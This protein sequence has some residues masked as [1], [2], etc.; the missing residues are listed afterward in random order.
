MNIKNVFHVKHFTLRIT[1]AVARSFG[2]GPYRKANFH[3]GGV[4]TREISNTVAGARV[5]KLT[6]LGPGRGRG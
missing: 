2:I 1:D 4:E 5:E 3:Q 6:K